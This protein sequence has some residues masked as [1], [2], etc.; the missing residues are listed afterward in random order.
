[1]ILD[2]T[3]RGKKL[4]CE[5]TIVISS[6]EIKLLRPAGM[7]SLGAEELVWFDEAAEAG[8][9]GSTDPLGGVHL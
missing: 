2:F 4:G 5:V 1:M 3:G 6:G 9:P 8:P 7:S